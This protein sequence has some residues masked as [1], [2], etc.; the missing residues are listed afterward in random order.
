MDYAALEFE[1]SMSDTGKIGIRGSGYTQRLLRNK[2]SRWTNPTVSPDESDNHAIIGR[3]RYGLHQSWFRLLRH[4]GAQN[5][6]EPAQLHIAKKRQSL[7][8][9]FYF[10]NHVLFQSGPVH[11]FLLPAVLAL[12]KQP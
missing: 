6:Q 10:I 9:G 3:N 4:H 7:A 8:Q 11:A 5:S 2:D 12:G 1:P